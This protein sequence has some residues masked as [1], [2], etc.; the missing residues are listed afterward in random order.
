MSDFF[1]GPFKI[2]HGSSLADRGRL[3]A[4]EIMKHRSGA[5]IY[6]CPGCLSIAFHVAKLTGPDDLPSLDRP[7]ICG[8]GLCKVQYNLTQGKAVVIDEGRRCGS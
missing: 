1:E 7:M 6:R 2:T 3:R 4:G 5:L 8:C